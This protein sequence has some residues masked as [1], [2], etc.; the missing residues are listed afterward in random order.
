MG[1]SPCVINSEI[2]LSMQAMLQNAILSKDKNKSPSLASASLHLP[3][4]GRSC[5]FQDRER[6]LTETLAH[7]S[8]P[9]LE[10]GV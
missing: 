8:L 7:S 9:I 3:S 5:I 2:R 10:F 6:L 4:K 1:Y